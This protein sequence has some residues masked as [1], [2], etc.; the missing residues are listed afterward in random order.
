MQGRGEDGRRAGGR[1]GVGRREQLAGGATA[2]Q[3]QALAAEEPERKFPGT[4]RPREG[5]NCGRWPIGSRVP[6]VLRVVLHA[7][8]C[9]GPAFR[10][11]EEPRGRAAGAAGAKLGRGGCCEWARRR[12]E[13]GRSPSTDRSLRTPSAPRSS[14]QVAAPSAR[15]APSRPAGPPAPPCRRRLLATESWCEQRAHPVWNSELRRAV[16]PLLWYFHPDYP[17]L[18]CSRTMKLSPRASCL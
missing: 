6:R 16:R 4:V 3:T 15:T 11:A 17:C 1:G 2:S 10:E 8:G 18:P 7:L 14:G 9:P 13:R 5:P 12:G